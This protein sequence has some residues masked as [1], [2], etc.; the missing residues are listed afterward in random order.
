MQQ[1]DIPQHHQRLPRRQ[2]DILAR[3]DVH[4]Q[5]FSI[6]RGIHR[7]TFQLHP[8][9]LNLGRGL[10]HRRPRHRQIRLP[11]PG[12]EQL[13]LGFRPLQLML[14]HPQVL[15]AADH[16]LGRNELARQQLSAPLFQVGHAGHVRRGL[17]DFRLTRRNLFGARLSLQLPQLGLH[18]R[19]NRLFHAQLR[20]H[21]PDIQSKQRCPLLHRVAHLDE[22]FRD[23]ARNMRADGDVLRPRLD[24]ARRANLPAI[25]RAGRV[26]GRRHGRLRP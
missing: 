15:L 3:P 20:L 2:T 21:L 14:D 11:R 16:F 1:G 26:T 8:Q 10:R 18:R 24:H 7:V 17:L 6:D 5:N 13:V 9:P 4:L 12:Q 23:H 22:H 19:Q 25:G